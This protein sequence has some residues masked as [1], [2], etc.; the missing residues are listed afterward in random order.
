MIFPE[1]SLF[2]L[3][4]DLELQGYISSNSDT[5]SGCHSILSYSEEM[6]DSDRFDQSL[7]SQQ[8]S[9]NMTVEDFHSQQYYNEIGAV[10]RTQQN[11]DPSMH[12]YRS[13]VLVNRYNQDINLSREISP[14]KNSYSSSVPP[15]SSYDG[16]I[17][18][19]Y[20]DESNLPLQASPDSQN[21]YY[22]FNSEGKY[23]VN[24]TIFLK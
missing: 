20:P 19:T 1:K 14:T 13:D 8:T 7:E 5:E 21:S 9:D 23:S 16:N 12:S 17:Y 10:H 15:S 4:D 3:H 24:V 11:L 6:T 2:D 22:A 18:A